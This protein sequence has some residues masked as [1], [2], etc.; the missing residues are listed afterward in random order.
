MVYLH[1]VMQSYLDKMIAELNWAC[2][3]GLEFVMESQKSFEARTLIATGIE[4]SSIPVVSI[5]VA[6]GTLLLRRENELIFAVG[7]PDKE[8]DGVPIWNP[9]PENFQRT[10]E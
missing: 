4:L 2:M 8:E 3:P 5:N 6:G 1:K 9:K 7:Y 10:I